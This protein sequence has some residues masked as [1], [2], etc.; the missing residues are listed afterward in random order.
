MADFTTLSPAEQAQQ[1][2]KPEGGLGVDIDL[3]ELSLRAY[4]VLARP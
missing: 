1:L 2:G 3:S 4:L